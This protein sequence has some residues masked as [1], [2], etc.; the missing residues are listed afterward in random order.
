MSINSDHIYSCPSHLDPTIRSFSHHVLILRH[1]YFHFGF[2]MQLLWVSLRA[3]SYQRL[4]ETLL[5]WLLLPQIQLHYSLQNLVLLCALFHTVSN[6]RGNLVSFHFDLHNHIRGAQQDLLF[7]EL[8]YGADTL[9]QIDML[10]KQ[11]FPLRIPR[12]YIRL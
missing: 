5:V 9:D 8:P 7:V 12:S 1:G 3:L 6:D 4:C 10:G 2:I 11:I